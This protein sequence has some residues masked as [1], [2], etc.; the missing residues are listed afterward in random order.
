MIKRVWKEVKRAIQA[1][2]KIRN[3]N[4]SNDMILDET[5]MREWKTDYF[6]DMYG[7]DG[8]MLKSNHIPSSV[9]FIYLLYVWP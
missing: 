3:K 4:E 5:E 8:D 2:K 1:A 9:F 6:R 7:N